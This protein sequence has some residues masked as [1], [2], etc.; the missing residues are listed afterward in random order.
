MRPPSASGVPRAYGRFLAIKLLLRAHRQ[1]FIPMVAFLSVGGVALGVAA[2][3][4]VLA[5]MSGF[6]TDLQNKITAMSAH[7]WVQPFSSTPPSDPPLVHRLRGIE[8]IEA[9]GAYLPAQALLQSRDGASG[10]VLFGIDGAAAARVVR[11]AAH[12]KMGHLPAFDGAEPE[13]V[14]GAELASSLQVLPGDPLVLVTARSIVQPVPMLVRAR[15]AAIFEVGMYDYDAHTAYLP[16]LALRKLV[17]QAPQAGAMVRVTD[18]FHAGATAKLASARLGPGYA[19]RDWLTMN[20]NLFYAIRTEKVV[21]FLILMT[22]VTVAAFNITSSLIMTVL[23]KTRAIGILGA[24]GVPPGRIAR[25]F[26]T[27]GTLIG[28]VGIGAGVLVGSALCAFIAVYPLKLPGGGSVYYLSTLPVRMNPLLDFAVIPAV[29]LAL[30]VLA[31]AY[32]ARVAARLD[33]A[34]A[35]RHE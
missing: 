28:A 13:V 26:I 25:I 31:A 3:I 32:P 6:E 8:G 5:V 2:L 24:I 17:G 4:L 18:M 19:A 35:I 7:I 27:Q 30:C 12:L 16:L 10:A 20:R 14:L 1:R 29:A 22:I 15:V 23:E 34:E 21:M 9:A 11:I 33:P